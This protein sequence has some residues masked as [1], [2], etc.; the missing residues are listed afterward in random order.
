MPLTA[1]GRDW[2]SHEHAL[3]LKEKES[4]TQYGALAKDSEQGLLTG[5]KLLWGA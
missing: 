2:L 4:E 5:E 1:L 3:G